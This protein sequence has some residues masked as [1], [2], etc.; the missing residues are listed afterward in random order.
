[1][2]T[3][4]SYRSEER[5][6]RWWKFNDNAARWSTATYWTWFGNDYKGI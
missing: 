6:Y 3:F 2:I 1:M 4:L 5:L